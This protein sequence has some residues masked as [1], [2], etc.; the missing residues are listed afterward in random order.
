MKAAIFTRYGP[1]EVLQIVELPRPE[2]GPGEVL[3]R[4]CYT[5]A[6]AGDARVRGFN[7]PRPIFWVPGRLMLGVF[8][9]RYRL[10]GVELSGVVEKVGEGVDKFAVGDE[11]FAHPGL[12]KGRGGYAEFIVMGQDETVAKKPTNLTL[13][14]SVCLPFGGLTAIYFLKKLGKSTQGQRVLVVGASG[15]VGSAAVQ[16][17]KHFGA[18]VTGVCSTANVELVRSLGADEV[19]DY[20]TESYTES[21]GPYDL[22]FDAVGATRFA[23]CK[24]VMAERGVYLA[25]VMGAAEI[26]Q[27]L[28]TPIFGKRRVKSGVSEDTREDLLLVKELAESGE[29]VPV[30]DSV[31]GF[32]Q[33]VDAHRRVDE[34]RK[35]G[36]VVVRVGDAG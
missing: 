16:I 20:K 13:E 27:M 15:S 28:W 18:H 9:P 33:I 1:P 30:Q 12:K 35:R 24:R 7:L 31:F 6:S 21:G 5:T 19:I 29:F 34:W 25:A 8:R 26:F 32:E 10:L 22:V 2:P 11:V 14:E 3:I 17:A 23:R 4:V 36:S